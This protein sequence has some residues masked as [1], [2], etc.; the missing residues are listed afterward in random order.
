MDF[1]EVNQILEE[2]GFVNT[3]NLKRFAEFQ[4]NATAKFMYLEKDSLLR[5]RMH[6]VVQEDL[7][8]QLNSTADLKV[9]KLY[10]STNMRHFDKRQHGGMNPIHYGVSVVPKNLNALTEFLQAFKRL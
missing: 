2:S 4:C 3:H 8:P 1:E 6:F 7:A 9:G 5:N 10:H